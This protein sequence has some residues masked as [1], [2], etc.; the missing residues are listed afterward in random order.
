MNSTATSHENAGKWWIALAS[1]LLVCS[2]LVGVMIGPAGP[3]WWRVPLELIN[4]LPFFSIHS[5]LTDTDWS[6]VWQI[7][8]PRVVLAAL[9]GST[10]SI[11][12]ASYQGVFR[13]P[14]VDPYLLGVA[15]GAG[16]GA[17][18]VITVNRSGTS[19][20]WIDPL[21][22][23]AFIGGL[24]AVLATYLVGTTGKGERSSTSLV[25]SG[26]AVTSLATAAQTFLLQRNS[27]VVRQVYSWILGRLSSATW[28]DVR[29]VIP[30]VVLST[31]ALLLHRRLLDVLRVGDDEASALGVNV[32]RV[33]LVVVIA[34][35]LGTASVVAV[36]GLIGFVGI[37]VPHAVRL[38]VG[39]SYRVV[40]PV[41]LLFGAAFLILADIPG[42]VLDNPAETP[43]GVV[44]AFLG[45]PFFLLILR[46]RKTAQ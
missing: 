38:I 37:I 24:I 15:A 28:G 42:R 23:A 19:T 46:A 3:A 33:R 40:L 26:V 32:S 1:L 17:T 36:S 12:G 16:L 7:R 31:I 11:A 20:W 34:A 30:Y 14:L 2:L 8:A 18:I 25:L 21:P 35:T 5:G 10:L 9:V 45:A 22:L 27:D 44:T 39:T 43:I 4:R 13:N 29:L 41:S 6:I